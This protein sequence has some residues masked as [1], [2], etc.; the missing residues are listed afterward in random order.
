MYAFQRRQLYCTPTIR[1]NHS[2]K[3]RQPTWNFATR[4]LNHS[5]AK[6][7]ANFS[8]LINFR[9]ELGNLSCLN[10]KAVGRRKRRKESWRDMKKLLT[11]RVFSFARSTWRIHNANLTNTAMWST[12]ASTK[13]LPTSSSSSLF[14]S[15]DSQP[16]FNFDFLT[17]LTKCFELNLGTMSIFGKMANQPLRLSTHRDPFTPPLPHSAEYL[18]S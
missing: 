13:R 10:S 15:V 12:S 16:D 7:T 5:S 14:A 6:F 4:K 1:P 2:P 8:R 11:F 3:N 18:H 9:F 17:K